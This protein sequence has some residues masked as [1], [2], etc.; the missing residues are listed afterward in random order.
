M[1]TEKVAQSEKLTDFM[2]VGGG[3]GIFD[4]LEF[5]NAWLYT[6]FS[7]AKTQLRDFLTPKNAFL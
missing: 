2:H 7:E 5:V 1:A 4:C 6:L 3:W